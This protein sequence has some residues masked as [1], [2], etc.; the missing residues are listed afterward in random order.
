[1]EWFAEIKKIISALIYK[2]VSISGNAGGLLKNFSI[3]SC[4]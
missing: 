3:M 2:K 1:M 4:F